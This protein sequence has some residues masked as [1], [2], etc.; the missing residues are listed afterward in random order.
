MT[1]TTNAQTD[2]VRIEIRRA[3]AATPPN[4][5]SLTECRRIVELLESF[6]AERRELV[7]TARRD[8]CTVTRLKIPDWP[9]GAGP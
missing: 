5:W 6:A 8:R 4:S 7:A 1:A 9:K 2:Q 3:L